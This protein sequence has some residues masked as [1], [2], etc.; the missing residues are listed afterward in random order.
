MNMNTQC[1]ISLACL[2]GAL[3]IVSAPALAE[4]N[5]GYGRAVGSGIEYVPEETV[6][7]KELEV[8]LPAAPKS[9]NLREFYV[10]AVATNHYF[11]DSSSLAVGNDGI[12]RYVLVVRTEGGAENVSFEGI[13]CAEHTWKL[14]ATGSTDGQWRTAR[15]SEWRPIENKPVNRYHAALSKEL[16]CPDGNPIA[17]A[18]EGR[19]ALQLGKHPNAK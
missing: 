10:S 9:G 12:V 18:D 13:R 6:E 4:R 3:C 16:F 17:T 2:A 15:I 5:D 1:K 19:R 8:T 7:W 11:I 14:Y